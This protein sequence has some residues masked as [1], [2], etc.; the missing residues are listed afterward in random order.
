[1]DE[2]TAI[3]GTNNEIRS[4]AIDQNGDLF[5]GGNFG[6]A[7]GNAANRIAKWDGT[8]WS[9]LGNG[10]SGF[11]QS[12]L[13][14]DQFVYIGGNFTNAGE[15]IANRIARWDVDKMEWSSLNQGLS[16]NVNSIA[17]DG[18]YIYVGGQF[19]NAQNIP[20]I[21]DYVVNN[22][23]RWSDEEGWSPLGEGT[24]L[25]LSNLVNTIT[26]GQGKLFVGGSFENAGN[27]EVQNIAIWSPDEILGLT[28]QFS[29][30]IDIYPNPTTDFINVR[31][32][33]D[34]TRRIYVSISSISGVKKFEYSDSD[35]PIDIS[36]L[37]SG[38]Y[39][40]RVISFNSKHLLGSFKLIVK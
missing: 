11:V 31:N 5:V 23:V 32:R 21:M 3:A 1:V 30:D 20:P 26:F 4:I 16:N 12:I 2:S 27:T 15:I 19:T 9:A 14:T 24:D 8:S 33:F 35:M 40:L 17:T 22:I 10:T 36:I 37:E 29:D 18:N 28:S 7:G 6:S 25:G 13:I 38:I 39:I 34:P